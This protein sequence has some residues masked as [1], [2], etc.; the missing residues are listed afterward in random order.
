VLLKKREGEIPQRP[1]DADGIADPVWEFLE[2][3]WS[4]DPAKRPPTAQVYESLSK[5]RPLPGNLSLRVQGIKT[6]LK[7][8]KQQRFSVRFKY[9]NKYHT[10]TPTSKVV[11]GD[12]YTWFGFNPLLPVTVAKPWTGTARKPG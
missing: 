5:L 4:R 11:A 8:S 7:K 2:R 10:T 9:G 12:E 6:S 1:P 3:C